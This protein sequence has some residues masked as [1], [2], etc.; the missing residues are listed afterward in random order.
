TVRIP[1]GE[2]YTFVF[3]NNQ[4]FFKFPDMALGDYLIEAPGPPQEALIEIMAANGIDPSSAYTMGD[5]PANLPGTLEQAAQNPGPALAAYQLAVETFFGLHD[6]RFVG[7]APP[8]PGGYG[9]TKVKLFQDSFTATAN[10]H[11]LTE[12]SI[13][14]M[15]VDGDDRPAAALV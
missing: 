4:G 14:G 15:T 8:P 2:G 10:I 6:P 5:A 11:Y 3:A 13:S 9:W 12:G 7:V 1:Q